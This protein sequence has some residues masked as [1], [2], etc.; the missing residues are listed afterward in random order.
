MLGL[1]RD[2]FLK[3]GDRFQNT[4]ENANSMEDLQKM[5]ISRLKVAHFQASECE[6]EGPGRSLDSVQCFSCQEFGHMKRNCLKR[7]KFN[8]QE[9]ERERLA[10][11]AI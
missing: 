6:N 3:I 5:I 4:L 2:I 1:D 11:I 8:V 7:Q 9:R 10:I